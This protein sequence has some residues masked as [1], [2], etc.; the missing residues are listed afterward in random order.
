MAAQD[1]RASAGHHRLA[2]AWG[3]LELLVDIEGDERRGVGGD[4]GPQPPEEIPLD[5]EVGRDLVRGG[6]LI[7][8]GRGRLREAV[9]LIGVLVLGAAAILLERLAD[10]EHRG[11]GV[12]TGGAAIHLTVAVVRVERAELHRGRADGRVRALQVRLDTRGA[13]LAGAGAQR[14]LVLDP[15]IE[16]TPVHIPRGC[17]LLV[18]IGEGTRIWS[19][20]QD[21]AVVM[22]RHHPSRMR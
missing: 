18:R 5:L 12:L 11:A 8:L 2:T 14:P 22:W 15:G 13:R 20:A 21:R 19:A 1:A 4:R 17:G 7:H 6:G 9:H 16:P 10:G 3:I